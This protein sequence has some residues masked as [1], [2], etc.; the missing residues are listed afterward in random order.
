MDNS[1]KLFKPDIG[2]PGHPRWKCYYDVCEECGEAYEMYNLDDWESVVPGEYQDKSL[3][4]NCLSIIS[5]K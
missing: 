2:N 1:N 4:L 5:R 3:C